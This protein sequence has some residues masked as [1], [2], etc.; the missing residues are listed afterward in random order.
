MEL[1]VMGLLGL[2]GECLLD[3]GG[4]VDETPM[5]GSR[6]DAARPSVAQGSQRQ[7][8]CCRETH[9]MGRHLLRGDTCHG[10][11]LLHPGPG[12]SPGRTGAF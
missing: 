12:S 7:D 8:T 4:A 3:L 5:T 1:D 11:G 6:G 9:A 2:W 10:E